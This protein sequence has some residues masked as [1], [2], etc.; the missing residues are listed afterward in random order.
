MSVLIDY[1]AHCVKCGGT[2]QLVLLAQ[3]DAE[4]QMVGWLFV[5]TTCWPLVI[6]AHLDISLI[7]P[8][9]SMEIDRARGD[10][11]LLS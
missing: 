9:V 6:G 4:R 10:D 8:V 2:D 3:R 1:T 11:Q 7:Y 5:C